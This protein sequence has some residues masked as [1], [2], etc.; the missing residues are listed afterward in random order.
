MYVPLSTVNSAVIRI[1]DLKLPQQLKLIKSSQA[2]SHV[3]WLKITE[4]SGTISAPI[5]GSDQTSDPDVSERWSL[6]H[7]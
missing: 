2:I 7:P 5:I 4:I 1:Q 6:K 3:S